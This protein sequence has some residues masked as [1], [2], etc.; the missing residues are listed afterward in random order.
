MSKQSKTKI[1][2]IP[3]TYYFENMMDYYDMNYYDSENNRKIIWGIKENRRVWQPSIRTYQ[4][5]GESDEKFAKSQAEDKIKV[6]EF[7]EK[8]N[9]GKYIE[10]DEVV[11]KPNFEFNDKLKYLNYTRGRSSAKIH[12]K[13]EIT[14]K[15]YEMFLTDFDD[16]MNGQGFNKNIVE[17]IFTFCK[18]GANYGIKLAR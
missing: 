15:E 14:G 16:L 12:F 17:S 18:R 2:M 11:W 9:S 3:F 6:E 1:L 5:Y 4:G 7:N 10:V 13:S 8:F